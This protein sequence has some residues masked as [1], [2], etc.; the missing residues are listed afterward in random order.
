MTAN[1]NN[2]NKLRI[3]YLITGL[4]LGGAESQ[5]LLL[6]SHIQ[7]EGHQVIVLAMESG[8][9]MAAAFKEKKIK[10]LELD[11]KGPATLFHGY[12]RLK[13]IIRDF[14]P[15]L[16]HT[17]MI[18][19][20]LFARIFK[21]FNLRYKLINTAH[22]ILEGNRL[23]MKG[24]SWTSGLSNW[25]T[26]V[27]R[28]AFNHFIQKGYFS[29]RRSSYLPNAIDILQ[30]CPKEKERLNLRNE[31][32]IASD[33]YL[34][35]SAGRLHE[36]KDHELLLRS[37]KELLNQ[38]SAAVLFIA[39]EGPLE[40]KLKALSVSLGIA[41]QT[42]FLGRREDIPSLLNMCDCFV[43]SS[44]YEGF[45]LVTAEALATMKPVIATDCGG[46]KEVIGEYGTL[47]TK[48][49]LLALSAAMANE[50][51][52][53]TTTEKLLNGRRH[54]EEHYSIDSVIGQWLHLYHQV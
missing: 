29:S 14:S 21:L 52:C 36:Q 4:R 23:L 48:G 6:A 31:F 25:S 38:C 54:I 15:D 26:N 16:I 34:F 37:F 40:A 13:I 3:L 45:G 30:F 12:Q 27:S 8:G 9:I 17:H 35:F 10:V 50:M 1:Q 33:A 24:Y 44:K 32:C 47:V 43:L 42:H 49:D 20:N 11:I 51:K 22:N 18:H 28:E 2:N 53:P 39:G 7:N 46:V 19:A 41:G 5:L